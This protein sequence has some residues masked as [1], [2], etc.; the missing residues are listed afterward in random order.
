MVGFFSIQKWLWWLGLLHPGPSNPPLPS[1]QRSHFLPVVKQL[2]TRNWD[3]FF[4]AK[5]PKSANTSRILCCSHYGSHV[6]LFKSITL[7]INLHFP[8]LALGT[9]KL[10]G[11]SWWWAMPQTLN[12]TSEEKH[13]IW[14]ISSGWNTLI[15]CPPVSMRTHH[16]FFVNL[17]CLMAESMCW[18]Q[19]Y[20]S[21]C[22]EKVVAQPAP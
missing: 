18:M 1:L 19:Y 17:V 12:T 8:Y 11:T 2:S 22:E 9:A 6:F 5:S 20:I 21:C 4:M 15:A 10:W 7:M 14:R 3:V 13:F 16:N